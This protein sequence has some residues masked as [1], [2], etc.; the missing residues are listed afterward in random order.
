MS[1]N[2]KKAATVRESIKMSENLKKAA[3]NFS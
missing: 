3:M 2:L 1:E